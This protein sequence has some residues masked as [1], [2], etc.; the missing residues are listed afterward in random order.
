MDCIKRHSVWILVVLSMVV[1][2]VLVL[3]QKADIK[4]AIDNL[5][6]Q[7]DGKVID[8]QEGYM[9]I[10]RLQ[11]QKDTIKP[12]TKL[13]IIIIAVMLTI[14]LSGIVLYS[15]TALPFLKY[16]TTGGD[17]NLSEPE[18]M[19]MFDIIAAVFKGVSFIV[20]CSIILMGL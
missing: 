19:K 2:T 1:I 3:E 20:G 8:R 15:F 13:S 4:S 17:G 18:R 5:A 6:L 10:E 14:P 9:Q 16:L 7:V 12:V 11:V